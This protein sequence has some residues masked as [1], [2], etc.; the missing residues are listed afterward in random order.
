[1][2]RDA[3][4]I[5]EARFAFISVTYRQAKDNVWDILK[6]FAGKIDGVIFNESELRADFLNGSRIK[7]YGADNPDSLRGLGLWGVVF[8]E[9]SQQPSNIFT[10]I[11]RPT[12]A[13]HNG[14]AIWIGT[15][16]GKNEFFR[17]YEQGQTNPEWLSML[18]TVEDTKL[19]NQK[20][21]DDARQIMTED[22]FNQEWFCSFEAAIK[23]AYYSK[24]LAEARKLNHIGK[25]SYEKDL[26]VYTYWDLGIDD[27]TAIGFFQF[28]GKEI[29]MIDYYENWGF[30]LDHYIK[31]LKDKPYNY[32]RHYFPPD[33]EVRE[34]TTG[35]SRR[36]SLEKMGITV[37]VVKKLALADGINA[38]RML[39]N[40]FWIDENNCAT[41]LDA[42][43]QYRAE[44]DDKNG[45]FRDHPL[46]DWTSHA[47]LV[48]DTLIKTTKGNKLIKDIT[49]QDIVKTPMGERRVLWAG[50]VKKT[51]NLIEVNLQD[52]NKITATPEHKFFTL[53]R[54]L[55]KADMLRYNDSIINLNYTICEK[56]LLYSRAENI[57][58]REAI[59]E[60]TTGDTGFA[61][62]TEQSGKT[63]ME[64]F[65]L[66]A[67]Y[68]IK[69]A[70]RLITE[71][72]IWSVLIKDSI[73]FR[74]PL[75]VN[76]LGVKPIK[77]SYFPLI[78]WQNNG[79]NQK[80]ENYGISNWR[81]DDGK[82]GI[83]K[84][85]RRIVLYAG[86]SL[87]HHFQPEL[88]FA[89][90][91]VRLKHLR[92]DTEVYD[93]TIEK[94]HCYYANNLL[95][96]NSDMLRYMSV[97]YQEIYSLQDSRK[98]EINHRQMRSL[99]FNHKQETPYRFH[100]NN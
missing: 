28:S 65:Q 49:T 77:N 39:F 16:K 98:Q 5:P 58:F 100:Y 20:E 30:G 41:F 45:K 1:L 4:N 19:I 25:V 55:V 79:T 80:L 43:S 6:Q 33:I 40:R 42:I 50:M 10:E 74:T 82:M 53:R 86:K 64:K 22:E 31:V 46:H 8:D 12:L 84:W 85:W 27:S 92:E 18:L 96:S 37:N 26:P 3:V 93:L 87:K 91:I 76:G 61:V 36:E 11:I 68:I 83:S 62:Y 44:W 9:Y 52:G 60:Q 72:K 24:D 81:K 66:I 47:C 71:L 73:F 70:T 13:D 34:L 95:V 14:Y 32:E 21:L 75:T 67:I 54:G 17:L 69:M 51:N 99:E 7:L 88:N 38:V 56:N 94:D 48:G 57:G 59:I 89:T 29:R 23:G 35:R 63:L 78:I 90:K 97:S 2:I 15:P